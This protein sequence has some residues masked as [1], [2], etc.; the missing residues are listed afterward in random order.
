MI[1]GATGAVG[2]AL[3]PQ[4]MSAG[5]HVIGTSR[6]KR[7]LDDIAAAGA[8]G[9]VM[10]GL[11]PASVRGAVASAKPDVVV[12]QLSA[13]AG[14]TDLK[15][16][17]QGFATTNR[18]RTEGTDHL[19]AAM[20]EQ[21]VRRIVVQSYTGWPNS[22]VSRTPANESEPLD[23]TPPKAARE[24]LA[25]SRYIE[26]VVTHDADI[27]GIA[28]RYGALYGP[29]TGI[30]ADGDV[31]ELIQKRKL[32]VVG[33]G[34]GI[35]SLVHVDDAAS[36]TVLALTRG[37]RAVYNIVD[38]DPAEVSV[39]LPRLAEIIG[40]PTPRRV[41]AWLAKPMIGEQGVSLMTKVR[42]ASNELAKAELGWTLLYPS[43]RDGFVTGL[44]R[45]A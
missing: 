19:L 36:A 40:A 35:W 2:R 37:S 27:D 4:L 14:M 31:V 9:T 43:W 8:D 29:G 28:L 7:R 10:D 44:G 32:P 26:H 3:I 18:L 15:R 1:A 12:H 21:G 25:A 42:G 6:S 38:D 11:D 16:F 5:H 34:S 33:G 41:P 39:W 30:A 20:R 22:R 24:T 13:L 23:P 45:A 17:D